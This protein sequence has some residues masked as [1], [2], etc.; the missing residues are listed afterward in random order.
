MFVFSFLGP[1]LVNFISNQLIKY[2]IYIVFTTLLSIIPVY[3][4]KNISN[5]STLLKKDTYYRESDQY[6]L[7]IVLKQKTYLFCSLK[8]TEKVGFL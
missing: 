8:N 5:S 6:Q 3:I 2:I 4:L 7:I 1:G